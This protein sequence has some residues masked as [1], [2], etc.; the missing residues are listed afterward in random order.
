[1]N[2]LLK[3]FN[4]ELPPPKVLLTFKGESRTITLELEG[5]FP[6]GLEVV[7]VGRDCVHAQY[8]SRGDILKME[9]A[10]TEEG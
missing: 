5:H 9:F 8:M 3:L 7:V 6:R 1:M 4:R 10:E 2:W